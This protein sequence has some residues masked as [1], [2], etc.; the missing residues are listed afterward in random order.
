MLASEIMDDASTDATVLAAGSSR[1]V[2]DQAPENRGHI[3]TIKCGFRRA[4]HVVVTLDGYG[5]CWHRLSLGW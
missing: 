1:A 2:T 3:D 5:E 4:S